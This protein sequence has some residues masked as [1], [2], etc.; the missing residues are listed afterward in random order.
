MKAASDTEAS[1]DLSE[2]NT[3]DVT[4]TC[5]NKRSGVAGFEIETNDSHDNA[6]WVPVA[7]RTRSRLK[8][9]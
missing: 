8:T 2:L 4:S 3:S 6:F 9:S 5:F 1:S 7:Y